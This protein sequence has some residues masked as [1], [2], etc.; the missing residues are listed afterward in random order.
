VGIW[1]EGIDFYAINPDGTK[2]WEFTTIGPIMSSPAIGYDG[3]IYVGT[4]GRS[5][6]TEGFL[7]AI[8]PD[9]TKKWEFTTSDIVWSSPAIGYDGTIYVGDLK[10][11]LYAINPDGTKK[12]EFEAVD[13]GWSSPAIGDDGVIYIG[14]LDGK[15]YAINPDGTKKWE[16]QTSGSINSSPTIGTDGTVYVGSYDNKLYA[17]YSDSGGLSSSAWPMFHQNI[18]HTGR[19]IGGGGGWGCV[20]YPS[21]LAKSTNPDIML[22]VLLV[23]AMIYVIWKYKWRGKKSR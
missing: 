12:W 14:S 17:I 13:F 1:G 8:N 22:P 10:G 7:Y 2:K 19:A 6:Q 9:G 4:I 23:L 3:T 5:N 15:L 21:T 20:P 11:K 18:R 16:F